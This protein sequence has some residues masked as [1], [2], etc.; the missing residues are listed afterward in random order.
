MR[1]EAEVLVEEGFGKVRR[2]AVQNLPSQIALPRIQRL[3]LKQ[4]AERAKKAGR[5]YVQRVKWPNADCGKVRLP[6]EVRSQLG[7]IAH[8][9]YVVD[10]HGIAQIGP[11]GGGLGHCGL[12]LHY[13]GSFFGC[14][15]RRVA[16]QR[17]HLCHVLHV[18]GADGLE[19]WRIHNVV[20]AVGQRQATLG[21]FGNLFR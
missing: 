11:A 9:K 14:L 6:V 20:V 4:S 16:G 21:D 7:K 13:R 12:N 17:K 19:V 10:L 1:K 2:L 15:L 8:R 18:R 5:G 3:L